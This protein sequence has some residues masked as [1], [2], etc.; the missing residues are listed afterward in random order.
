MRNG[1]RGRRASLIRSV[2]GGRAALGL[3]VASLVGTALAG[4]VG[5]GPA[6]AARLPPFYQVPSK[7]PTT[8]G[9]LI[10]YRRMAV[11]GIDGTAY[12]VMYV[13]TDLHGHPVAVTGMVFVP[14]TPPPAGGYDVVS[15]AHGTVGMAEQ[16]APSLAA[17]T[18]VQSSTPELNTLLQHGWLVT[19]SDYRGLGTP[20]PLD[21][22]VG[23]L[24]AR[25]TIDIVRAVQHVKVAHAGHTY[26]V[27]GHSEGGQTA[28]FALHIG[29]TYAPDLHLVGVVAGAPPS[30]FADIYAFLKTSPYRFYLF[31]A[32]VGF[33]HAYGPKAAPL[34][35]ILTPRAVKLEPVVNKGCFN[36]LERTID[37][38]SLSQLVRANPF[39]EPKWRT[40]LSENDPESFK[41]PSAVP[42]LI[43]QGGAD[44]QIPPVSTQLLTQHLCSI[45]QDVERWIYPGRTHTSVIPPATPDFT[46]W[47]ADRFAGDPS[48]DPYQP[49]GQ[50]GVQTTTCPS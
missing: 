25:D 43:Y 16:C 19:A 36:Y 15:W 3:V 5:T 11:P 24:A 18:S 27:W 20:G 41:S 40:L 49:V 35:E 9:A 38:Y 48:P 4:V 8:P 10:K 47:M 2:A 1:H 45:G 42:L 34:K 21:Y 12:R 46:H 7:I 29:A 37:R 50:P 26:I 23:V 22:L 44:E 13:S 28:M 39:S 33:E 17:A 14:A 32:G 30:Q 31:M 6:A